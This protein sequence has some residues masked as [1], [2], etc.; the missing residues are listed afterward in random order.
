MKIDKGFSANFDYA[1]IATESQNR[2]S[3]EK[4]YQEV[5]KIYGKANQ[6]LN[7]AALNAVK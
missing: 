7:G 3:T 4:Y 6:E 5:I 1:Q 2:Y